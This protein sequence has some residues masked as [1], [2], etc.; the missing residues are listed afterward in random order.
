[1]TYFST[2]DLQ[3]EPPKPFQ[4]VNGYLKSLPD[5]KMTPTYIQ[6]PLKAKSPKI[7]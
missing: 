1:M 5:E 7:K 6:S 4:E 3:I 2:P